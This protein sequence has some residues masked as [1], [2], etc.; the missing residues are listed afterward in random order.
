VFYIFSDDISWCKETLS[1]YIPD[2]RILKEPENEGAIVDLFSIASCK[3]GIMSPSTFSWW[4]NWLRRDQS[5]VVVL[6]AGNYAN[7][8]FAE[9]HWIQIEAN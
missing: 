4:G 6:P 3:H 8:F 1:Q 9:D 2:M 5:G 7:E